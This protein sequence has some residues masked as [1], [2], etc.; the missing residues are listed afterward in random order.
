MNPEDNNPL[1]NA[2]APSTT[3]DNLAG[4]PNMDG[5]NGLSMA[6]SLSSAEDNLTSAGLAATTAPNT[7]GLDQIG[8]TQPE[9]IM[10][11]PAEEPLIPAA[12]VP[13]S[14][15]SAISVPPAPAEPM[16]APSFGAPAAEAQPQADV[17]GTG[18]M[19]APE[20]APQ[21]AAQPNA[22]PF[23]P[24]ANHTAE[25]TPAAGTNPMTPINPAFQPAAPKPAKKSSNLK[26]QFNTLTLLFAI[27]SALLLITTI[28]FFVMWN[29]AK[30]NPK[31]VYVPQISDEES[32]E[33]IE[34]LS[35]ARENDYA[36]LAGYDHPA[37]GTENLVASYSNDQ[38][39]GVTV[40]YRITLDD[41]NGA[42]VANE[43]FRTQQDALM[44][45]IG[46]SFTTEYLVEGNVLNVDVESN[47]NLSD[48]D[49]K[50]LIYGSADA[51]S[52]TSLEAVQ[53][54]YA[55]NGYNCSVQ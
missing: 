44:A 28:T 27:L 30:N 46:N 24:F 37:M 6:D 15:G 17:M 2:G 54:H 9:A 11:P 4:V 32:T 43:N 45:I 55:A 12:P 22:A 26:Q 31:V 48:A 21:P 14:I 25:P 52:T 29:N 50:T 8:A 34:V 3:P 16:A 39:R 38:L 23:N 7:M 18:P 36:Y 53:T 40:N 10:T 35:C 20:V 41:E 49:A 19:P 13:G 1:N 33:S 47:G 5:Q 51:T 42:N